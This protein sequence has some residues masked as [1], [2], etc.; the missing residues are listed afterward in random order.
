[1]HNYSDQLADVTAVVCSLNSA[2]S[3]RHCLTFLTQIGLAEVIVVDGG[4]IDGTIEIV[5]GFPVRLL[6]DSGDGLGAARNLGLSE[7]NSSLVL[8]VGA[9]NIVERNTVLQ[10]LATL[11]YSK[12]IAAVGCM[13]TVQEKS[14]L[15]RII[16]LQWKAKE[17]PGET[18]VVGTPNLFHAALLKSYRYSSSRRGSDDEDLC[19]RIQS[20]LALRFVVAESTCTEIGQATFSRFT[21]RYKLYG[22]SD[23]EVWN[24]NRSQWSFHRKLGSLAHPFNQEVVKVL[25][26]LRVGEI[27]IVIP[28]ALLAALLRYT[29]WALLTL[30][31]EGG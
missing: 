24:A 21:Q 13:T 29:Q 1:M 3:I 22:C 30:K 8:N 10:M 31:S 19:A 11:M 28:F 2:S 14:W 25:K 5:T 26:N 4:S 18:S 23:Y 15:G 27:L 16:N 9:D 7:C 12:D 17:R 20:D 6:K